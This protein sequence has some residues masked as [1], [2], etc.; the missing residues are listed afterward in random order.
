MFCWTL[1][2]LLGSF[3]QAV[4]HTP[5]TRHFSP[6]HCP[7]HT[8]WSLLWAGS[9]KMKVLC[10]V[11]KVPQKYTPDLPSWYYLWL[12]EEEA[13]RPQL[14]LLLGLVQSSR[15]SV[16]IRQDGASTPNLIVL[17]QGLEGIHMTYLAGF[18]AQSSYLVGVYCLHL[19]QNAVDF[20]YVTFDFTAQP[21]LHGPEALLTGSL[22][23]L[24]FPPAFWWDL[25]ADEHWLSSNLFSDEPCLWRSKQLDLLF[26][27]MQRCWLYTSLWESSRFISRDQ[28]GLVD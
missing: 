8:F 5:G 21:C 24:H 14:I 23:V 17:V 2:L 11:Y 26:S 16:P 1:C 28:T 19:C 10:L 4:L 6:D 22:L 12:V 9:H 3:P 15:L 20:P 18:L 27:A 13:C 25:G 7:S